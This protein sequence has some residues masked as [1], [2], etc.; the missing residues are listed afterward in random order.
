[1]TKAEAKGIKVLLAI[2]VLAF[3]FRIFAYDHMLALMK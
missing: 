3:L 1:M 2:V